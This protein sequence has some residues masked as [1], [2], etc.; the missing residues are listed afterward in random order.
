MLSKAHTQAKNDPT[1]RTVEAQV[2]RN[3][4][5]ILKMEQYLEELRMENRI[6]QTKVA[7]NTGLI[8]KLRSALNK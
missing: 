5:E 3:E 4:E 7:R 8:G 2:R 6:C 1:V